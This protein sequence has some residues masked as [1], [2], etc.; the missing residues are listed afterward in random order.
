MKVLQVHSILRESEVDYPIDRVGSPM[1]VVEI[2]RALGYDQSPVEQFI[3]L[4]LNGKH[5]I[6]AI[7]TI[8]KG[9]LN[10][11]V[12]HPRDVFGAAFRIGNVGAIIVAHNH[13]SGDPSPSA[14]DIA[15]TDR[16]EKAGELLGIPVIDHVIFGPTQELYSFKEHK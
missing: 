15:L 2:M 14:E 10:M 7:E 6:V 8:S 11:S 12:V 5:R 3:V 9:T 13:P 1:R 4:L 16:L